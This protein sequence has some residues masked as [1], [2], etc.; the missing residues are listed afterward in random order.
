MIN[1]PI[2]FILS[3]PCINI[4]NLP[5][6]VPQ[7]Q[8]LQSILYFLHIDCLSVFAQ[9]Y[10]NGQLFL[11]VIYKLLIKSHATFETMV[12]HAFDI[13]FAFAGHVCVG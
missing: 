6:V 7:L 10:I 9:Q 5:F 1:S 3:S 4:K 12:E 8:L 13:S 2:I 11:V